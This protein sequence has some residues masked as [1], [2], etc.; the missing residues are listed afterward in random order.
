MAKLGILCSFQR[1]V[2]IEHFPL[3]QKNVDC[4]GSI[5]TKQIFSATWLI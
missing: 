4:T 1:E 3:T 2:L 5:E